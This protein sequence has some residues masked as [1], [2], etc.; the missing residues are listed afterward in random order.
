MIPR[1]QKQKHEDFIEVDE[2]TFNH[3]I[4]AVINGIPTILGKG[5]HEKNEKLGFFILHNNN[6]NI[7]LGNGYQLLPTADTPA[8]MI[9]EAYKK[10]PGCEIRVYE[11]KDWKQALKFL[12]N[13]A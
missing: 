10:F 2:I 11:S 9:K 6:V 1:L 13:N 8:S 4:V 3:L 5:Y 12:I 7:T